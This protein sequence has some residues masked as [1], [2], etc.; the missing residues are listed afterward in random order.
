MISGKTIVHRGYYIIYSIFFTKVKA[1][2]HVALMR[3]YCTHISSE[4]AYIIL[5]SF[6]T[7]HWSFDMMGATN[8]D[9]TAYPFGTPELIRYPIR[10][11]DT[12][13]E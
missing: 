10:V 2:L 13:L 11:Q 7:Y 12:F 4:N 3:L 9:E 5:S 6:M 1:V 8:G